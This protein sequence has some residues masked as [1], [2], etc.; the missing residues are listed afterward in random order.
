MLNS[1]ANGN[2]V[3]CIYGPTAAGK[4][5]LAMAL[6]DRMPCHLISV[7]SAL[8]Y[9]GMD[10]GTAKPTQTELAKYPHALIDICDPAESYSAA[11]FVK[12]AQQ[13]IEIAWAA[14]KT[15]VLV[16]GTMLYYKALLEGLSP[17]PK[18]SP[19]IRQQIEQQAA[20]QGWEALHV[21]LAQVDPATAKRVHPNDPQRLTRALEVFK[22][23]GVP[24]SVLQQQAGAGLT[25]P[26]WQIAVAPSDR[27]VLHQ[28]IEQRFDL[29]LAN[30]F[31]AEVEKLFA[32]PD[33]HIE[34]PAIRCV[35]YRQMWLYLMGE[36][37]YEAM[38]E[39][40]I[41]ATRQLAKRQL[42]WLRT[43]PGVQ[44]LAPDDPQLLE[45]TAAILAQPPKQFQAWQSEK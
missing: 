40:G 16:G 11:R 3:I 8:I 24:L 37:S 4:T 30:N 42:T 35:G 43:W 19:A 6:Q 23:T 33:L 31:Q 38:R 41:I 29:M 10:I 7:D 13:Q 20:A 21:E 36:L 18:A 15:P 22:L 2:G 9:R 12:D 27:S 25:C 28:R 32:R 1:D 39:R 26:I 5:A 17:L 45:K 34:L 14:N 44:W